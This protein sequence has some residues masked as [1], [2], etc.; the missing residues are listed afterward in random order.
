[1]NL[2]LAVLL[3]SF[4]F[5]V[6]GVGTYMALSPK[7]A[8][9]ASQGP[10]IQREGPGLNEA[11]RTIQDLETEVASLRAQ[12]ELAQTSPRIAAGVDDDAIAQAVE[13]YLA[14]RATDLA[15]A[16]SPA[17]AGKG[18]LGS[19]DDIFLA[20][21]EADDLAAVGLWKKIVAEGRDAEVLAHFK[22][23]ADADPNNPE[24]QLALGQ[25]YLGR[26]QEA[27][28]SPLAGKYATLADGA[29]NAALE[30][31]PGHWEARFTKA[32]ALSFWPDVFGKKAEAIQNYEMLIEQQGGQAPVARHAQTH[33]L[34][35]N[36]YHQT[37]QA[38][39]ALA[40]WRA[41]LAL[42]PDNS[43]LASQIA[44]LS[45]GQ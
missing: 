8:E 44:I 15:I 26:T 17:D 12:M 27:G 41:G 21:S 6:G 10:E 30:V 38:D 40:T 37:G 2:P 18:P 22:A 7:A 11:M 5:A 24:A 13:A 39:K 43:D 35:G 3:S 9:A 28:A 42:F 31:D 25:A 1:M 32:T 33:L 19:I 16:A 23:L 45:G 20:L 36:M 34:L 14:G 29:L 4:G